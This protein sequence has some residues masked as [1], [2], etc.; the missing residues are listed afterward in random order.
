MQ[1]A[2]FEDVVEMQYKWPQNRWPKDPKYKELGLWTLAN[3]DEGLE[4]LSLALF[5]R[6]L[7]WSKEEVLAYLVQVRRDIRST[8]IHAYWSIYVVYGRK[9]KSQ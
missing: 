4:G 8:R 7:G 1:A 5:T 6:G 9:P 3:V 2:G